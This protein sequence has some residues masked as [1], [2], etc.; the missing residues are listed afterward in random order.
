MAAFRRQRLRLLNAHVHWLP[1]DK[2]VVPP[3]VRRTSV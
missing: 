3:I 1:R 2:A